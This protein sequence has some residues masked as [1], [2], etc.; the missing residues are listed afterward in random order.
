MP[1]E[2]GVGFDPAS[3]K[4]GVSAIRATDAQ[5]IR[6][7][8]S[9]LAV[10]G[11]VVPTRLTK[12][13]VKI[14]DFLTQLESNG[15]TILFFAMENPAMGNIVKRGKDGKIVRNRHDT[16]FT[17]G[18]AF[19]MTWRACESYSARTQRSISIYEVRPAD[20]SLAVGV[21]AT[22]SKVDRNISTCRL[23]GGQFDLTGSVC[24][25]GFL[26][27]AEPD[28]LDANAAAIAGWGLWKQQ[29]R[30]IEATTKQQNAAPK[31]SRKRA[32]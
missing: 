9:T 15:Y 7:W 16:A 30:I 3:F 4:L 6:G 18:R 25:D 1:I 2:V 17:L 24:V 26:D 21:R 14:I 12:L 31:K 29:V 27:Q 19:E 22:S 20:S 11:T 28:G 13:S 8:T 23:A 10:S 5:P 32:A